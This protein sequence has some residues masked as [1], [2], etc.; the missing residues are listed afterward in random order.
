M[1]HE[2]LV[3]QDRAGGWE[4]KER[5][6]QEGAQVTGTSSPHAFTFE[7]GTPKRA[8]IQNLNLVFPVIIKVNLSREWSGL[9]FL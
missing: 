9:Y 8:R 5:G 2:D 6:S 4:Q 1:A 7:H 3:I